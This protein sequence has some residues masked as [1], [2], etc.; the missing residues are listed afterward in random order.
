MPNQQSSDFSSKSIYAWVAVMQFFTYKLNSRR[1]RIAMK[2]FW[3]VY[4]HLI[5]ELQIDRFI[6]PEFEI[7]IVYAPLHCLI[8]YMTRVINANPEYASASPAYP[9]R[10]LVSTNI[11]RLYWIQSSQMTKT[12]RDNCDINIVQ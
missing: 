3:C 10:T 1:Q 7:T 4:L 2:V 12:F 8:I 11:W 9:C 6:S 5:D